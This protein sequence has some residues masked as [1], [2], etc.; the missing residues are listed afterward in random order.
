MKQVGM[1]IWNK[2]LILCV[3][4]L[5]CIFG[6]SMVVSAEDVRGTCGVSATWKFSEN[7]VL[8]ISGS[9]AIE[10]DKK[11]NEEEGFYMEAPWQS[12][13]KLLKEVVIEEGI[14]EIPDNAFYDD[15]DGN[16]YNYLEKVTIPDS[17]TKI[18]YDAF[19]GLTSLT[20]LNYS[21]NA[22][23]EEGAFT[24]CAGLA[25]ENGFVIVGNILFGYHTDSLMNAPTTITIPDGITR[26]DYFGGSMNA[27]KIV[28]PD[29]V[30]TICDRAFY[31]NKKSKLKEIVFSSNLQTIGSRAFANNTG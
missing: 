4:I 3:M 13:C 19:Y 22:E 20:T 25:D 14:T 2:R 23:I 28:M 11:G 27:E 24:G 17:V 7:G 21:G 12:Y 1:G 18:G 8:T 9:G 26:I 30:V 5:F 15:V 29:S 10:L 6:N 31:A 16:S